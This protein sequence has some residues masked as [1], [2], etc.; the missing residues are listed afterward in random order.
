MNRPDS[1]R[2][3]RDLRWLLGAA[4]LLDE[5]APGHQGCWRS[6]EIDLVAHADWFAALEA[7]GE[8]LDADPALPRGL[9][10]YAEELVAAFLRHALPRSS[11]KVGVPVR[12]AGGGATS[13][14]FDFLAIDPDGA[15]FHLEMAC[16]FYLARGADPSL[17]D[18]IG[19]NPHDRLDA[20]RDKL[21]GDQRAIAASDEGRRVLARLGVTGTLRS[22]ALLCGRLFY[23]VGVWPPPRVPAGIAPDH[24]HGWWTVA[25]EP[26]LPPAI[27]RDERWLLVGKREWM[28]PTW[29][30][31][32]A[33][34]LL[35]RDEV[36]ASIASRRS[37]RTLVQCIPAGAGTL[38]EVSRGMVVDRPPGG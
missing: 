30:P 3:V 22:R 11:L 2:A 16:K 12:R 18:F 20:K 15:A 7:G 21:L 10:H 14:E 32:G 25:G 24:P 5:D 8:A 28:A 17:V 23:P 37:P 6:E 26:V 36:G 31:N 34:D 29:R 4:P 1:P 38:H 19:T 27:D 33:S 9:G 35:R 13:G